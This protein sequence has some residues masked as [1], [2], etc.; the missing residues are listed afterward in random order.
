MNQ[1]VERFV[2]ICMYFGGVFHSHF[3]T[4]EV[5]K[6]IDTCQGK[7]EIFI[8]RYNRP[9]CQEFWVAIFE[10]T[11]PQI[12]KEWIWNIFYDFW[13]YF[14]QKPIYSACP[15][16]SLMILSDLIVLSVMQFHGSFTIFD[17]IQ[18]NLFLSELLLRTSSVC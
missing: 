10:S 3:R 1:I 8:F 2:D 6:F 15:I 9:S 5:W 14:V 12:L 11:R 18:P 4:P 7:G 16:Q 13:I 17:I